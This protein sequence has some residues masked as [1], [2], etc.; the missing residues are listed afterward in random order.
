[1]KQYRINEAYDSL[2]QLMQS[3][4]R[5]EDAILICKLREK[6]E[7]YYRAE[8]E[9]ERELVKESGGTIATNGTVA[10][11][12]E[13]RAQKFKEELGKLINEEVCV[14]AN[15]I[16]L[17]EDF[18]SKQKITPARMMALREFICFD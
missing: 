5:M 13:S 10:F 6:L 3:E 7:P 16:R 11:P 1:M 8:L 9:R 14:E 12:E 15:P 2:N 4:M 17:S 18:Y